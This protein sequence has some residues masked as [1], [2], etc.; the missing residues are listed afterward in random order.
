VVRY[1][2]DKGQIYQFFVKETDLPEILSKLMERYHFGQGRIHF[3][4]TKQM[5]GLN[6]SFAIHLRAIGL[7]EIPY[8]RYEVISCTKRG[9]IKC[10]SLRNFQI[11]GKF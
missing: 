2:L 3:P 9:W 6:G 4:V 11:N 10:N 8:R 1:S 5:A 7:I